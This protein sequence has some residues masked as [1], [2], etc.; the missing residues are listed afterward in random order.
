[1]SRGEFLLLT[2]LVLGPVF[3]WRQPSTTDQFDRRIEITDVS[4]EYAASE[5]RRD[6]GHPF[7]GSTHCSATRSATTIRQ[8]LGADAKAILVHRYDKKAW[9]SVAV[10]SEY[11]DRISAG[12]PEGG[13]LLRNRNWAEMRLVEIEG[14]VE[15][16]S[17]RKSRIEFANGY[18]HVED[19][20]GCEWWGRYLGADRGRWIVRK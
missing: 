19:D 18:A 3:V 5:Q 9:L 14:A 2:G 7:D 13:E 20:S 6:I 15:F 16:T 8:L 11:I 1:M 17:G 4:R 12:Q 10:V